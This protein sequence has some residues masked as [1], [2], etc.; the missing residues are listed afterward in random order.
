VRGAISPRRFLASL[1]PRPLSTHPTRRLFG[2]R[3]T[4]SSAV[5][6][7]VSPALRAFTEEFSLERGSILEFVSAY[8]QELDPGARVLDAGAGDAPYRE[9]FDHCTYVTTD[10]SNSVHT[11]ARGADIIASLDCLPIP[12]ASFDAVL[13]TQVLE[14]VDDPFAALIELYRVLRPGGRL[15][16]TVPLVWPLHEEP[17]DF[18]RYTP[19]SLESLMT[20]AGFTDVEVSPRNG[21]FAT[22]AQLLRLAPEAVGWPEDDGARSPTRLFEDL[23]RLAGQLEALDVVDERRILPLGY[24]GRAR[25]PRPTS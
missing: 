9:L 5:L 24:Q 1:L 2:R 3:T 10:W 15:G 8:A 11:G 6:A 19:H 17:F 12:D 21:Y 14:H 25:R 22:I 16:L 20:R 18:F 23:S 13:C 7:S 4:R